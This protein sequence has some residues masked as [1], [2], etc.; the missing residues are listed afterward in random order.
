RADRAA[1]R[2]G[3]DGA[4]GLAAD[5]TGRPDLR[6]RADQPTRRPRRRRSDG[7]GDGPSRPALGGAARPRHRKTRVAAGLELLFH[8]ACAGRLRDPLRLAGRGA[9]LPWRQGAA[10]GQAWSG[11]GGAGGRT[12]E[13]RPGLRAHP[14]AVTPRVPALV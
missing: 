11:S 4:R 3:P 13:R 1:G 7:P 6:L 5:A 14:S 8:L 2:A 9:W 12:A 10:A